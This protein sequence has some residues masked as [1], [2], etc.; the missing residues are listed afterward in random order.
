MEI[1][2][3]WFIASPL[4]DEVDSIT[5]EKDDTTEGLSQ[6]MDHGYKGLAN[7]RSATAI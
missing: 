1:R 6:N 2:F 5:V 3:Q 7:G 4:L